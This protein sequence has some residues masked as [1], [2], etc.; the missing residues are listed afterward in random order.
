VYE[1]APAVQKRLLNRMAR[2]EGQARGVRQMIEEGR[3]CRDVILQIT[4]MRAALSRVAF[5]LLAANL[6]RCIEVHAESGE[7]DTALKKLEEVLTRL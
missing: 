6:E 4:A 2:V 3:D 1:I 7:R 5:T